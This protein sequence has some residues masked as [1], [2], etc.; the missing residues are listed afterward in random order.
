MRILIF[1]LASF[2]AIGTTLATTTS[3]QPIRVD[4][5]WH[6]S[7]DAQGH[8]VQLQTTRRENADRVPAVRQRLE[9]AI[10]TW[11]FLPGTV[12]GKPEV[13]ETGLHIR[14]ELSADADGTMKIRI[15]N[16]DVGGTLEAHQAAPRYPGAAI[17][18]QEQGEVVLRV[19]YDANGKV[20][21]SS[22]YPGAPKVSELLV[23]ASQDAVRKWRFT[24]ET[25]DGHG[26]AGTALAPFCFSLGRDRGTHC[27]WKRPG[28]DESL[29][30]G[31][32]LALN[33]AAKL[34][35]DVAGRT[36]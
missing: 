12:N 5:T 9:Q 24:P 2:F 36:L 17:R 27:D 35:T 14:A 21:S 8:V 22:M 28:S 23:Q 19:E 26:M 1:C 3:D 4:L 18:H 13:T 11:N 30:D 29:Q 10:H 33:P 20:T 31:E 6:A 15:L 25:V 7:I 32:A 16:A 34:L